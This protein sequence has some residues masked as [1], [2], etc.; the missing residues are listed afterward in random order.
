M[1]SFYFF[2]GVRGSRREKRIRVWRTTSTSTR[3]SRQRPRRYSTLVNS[4]Q[5]ETWRQSWTT[6][7][8]TSCKASHLNSKFFFGFQFDLIK[9]QKNFANIFLTDFMKTYA[10]KIVITEFA[11]FNFAKINKSFWQM[12]NITFLNNDAI[13]VIYI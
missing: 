7:S 12:W 11:S 4:S 3:P 6:Q 2:S 10:K 9:F 5:N 8:M 1:V 13:R